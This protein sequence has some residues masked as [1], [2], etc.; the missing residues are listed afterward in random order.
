MKEEII[1]SIF[2][3]LE[4]IEEKFFDERS[5][6]AERDKQPVQTEQGKSEDNRNLAEA[7]MPLV[8]S[9]NRTNR[10]LSVLRDALKIISERQKES[11]EELLETISS[12]LEALSVKSDETTTG[13]IRALRQYISEQ[14]SKPQHKKVIHDLTTK[15]W[16]LVGIGTVL[17]FCMSLLATK[18]YDQS[19]EIEELQLAGWKYRALRATLP[20][21]NA[22][23]IWLEHNVWA[24]NKDGIRHCQQFVINY[25]DSIR[26]RYQMEHEAA[27]RDN[28]GR[29]MIQQSEDI[30]KNLK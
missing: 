15:T 6:K 4:R 2:G 30:R 9:M 22:N 5:G 10:N 23:V 3:C 16:W 17:F 18:I 13:E 26:R 1:E 19:K 12:K 20:A 8:D 21:N 25:E 29:L 24:G 28:I 7:I 11:R 27:M 14:I